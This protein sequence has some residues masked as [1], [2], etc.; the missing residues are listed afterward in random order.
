MSNKEHYFENLLFAYKDGGRDSFYKC[1]END[2]NIKSITADAK[3]AI[4]TCAIYVIDCLDWDKDK[5]WTLL[6]GMI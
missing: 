6:D 3:D 2:S 5:V 4:E 1:M